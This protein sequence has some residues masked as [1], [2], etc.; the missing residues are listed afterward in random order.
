MKRL[1]SVAADK[2]VYIVVG[3][4][5]KVYVFNKHWDLM[6]YY[7]PLTHTRKLHKKTVSKVL[8]VKCKNVFFKFWKVCLELMRNTLLLPGC[9][10]LREESAFLP[11]HRIVCGI[12]V[13][14]HAKSKVYGNTDCRL[15]TLFLLVL[16]AVC[17]C[18]ETD[19]SCMDCLCSIGTN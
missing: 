14:R 13:Q 6:P 5:W 9:K 17:V 8:N 15:G 10:H 1:W 2:V 4:G 11:P 7:P 12:D 3:L 19:Q 18:V 16:F